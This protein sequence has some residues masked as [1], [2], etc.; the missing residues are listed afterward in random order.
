[1]FRLT[2]GVKTESMV[3]Q[4]P[5]AMKGVKFKLHY[6]VPTAVPSSAYVMQLSLILLQVPCHMCRDLAGLQALR[7][8]FQG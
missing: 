8:Q 5:L 7:R 2:K 6:W 3:T 4:L 1:M